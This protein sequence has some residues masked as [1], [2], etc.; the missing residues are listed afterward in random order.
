MMFISRRIRSDFLMLCESLPCGRLRLRTPEG[1]IH[2]FGQSGPEAEIDIHDWRMMPALA[3]RGD[4]GLG[5]TYVAGMWDTPSIEAL[6]AL[7]LRNIGH[8]G[9]LSRPSYPNR[10]KYRLVDRLL[11]SNSPAGAARNIRR[12]YD[13][14]NEFFQLWLDSGLTYSSALFDGTDGDLERAQRRKHD[15]ALDL[16]SPGNSLLDIGCGWG[17]FA[18]RAAE[19]GHRVTGITVSPS[20]KGY[21]DARLDG[22]ARIELRDYRAQTGRFSNI[23]SIEMIEAVGERHWPVYFDVL[24]ASLSQGG[25]IVLQAITVKDSEFGR[26]RRGSDF[27]RHHTFPGGMLLSDGTIA[28]QARRAGLAV[29][30]NFAFGT[31]YGRTCRIWAGRM[32]AQARKVL[33]L[34][35]DRQFLR[36]WLYYLE[37][38]A[39]SFAVG[40]TD[41]VQV[42]LSHADE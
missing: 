3:A 2:D 42:E 11:R 10:L 19:R 36:S 29:R 40:R 14:G 15:R 24:K 25:R 38:C 41:V 20:Q 18:E 4:I 12:H 34:G 27:I 16:L 37:I 26:Y 30:R 32:R 7:A 22:R 28:E 31:D 5:E 8:F 23:V 21:A 1:S 6:S 17:S 35:H 39:A 9:G 33:E 13:V